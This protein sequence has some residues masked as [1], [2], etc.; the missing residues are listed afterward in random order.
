MSNLWA[1]PEDEDRGHQ[2]EQ[3][4]VGDRPNRVAHVSTGHVADDVVDGRGVVAGRFGAERGCRLR[5][6]GGVHRLRG[7]HARLS[8]DAHV[9]APRS[10]YRSFGHRLSE[11][12][13]EDTVSLNSSH[14]RNARSGKRHGLIRHCAQTRESTSTAKSMPTRRRTTEWK[15]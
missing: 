5:P 6:C 3:E 7:W 4:H 2:S 12:T 13:S 8:V 14:L 11:P 1:Y 10:A 15:A 9:D